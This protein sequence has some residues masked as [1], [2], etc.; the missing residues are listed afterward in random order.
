[1]NSDKKSEETV[2]LIHGL[3]RT[4]ASM[5]PLSVRLQRAGFETA[6]VR[7]DSRRMTLNE[8][9]EAVAEQVS[10][11]AKSCSGPLHV[12]GHSLG[13]LI[14]LRLKRERPD[15]RIRRVVQCGSPNLGSSVAETLKSNSLAQWF[16]GPILSE[17]SED[18]TL[19]DHRDPD[20]AAIAGTEF[21]KG[22]AKVFGVTEPNDGLVTARSAWGRDAGLRLSA[23]TFHTGLP[24]SKCVADATIEFLKTGYAETGHD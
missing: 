8:A 20:I 4:R 21:P 3:G 13:G 16:F 6:M 9:T 22:I 12:V 17:L 23:P 18:L 24:L 15:L 14:A 7:Y 10:K 2:V 5:V 11:I 1:M 19:S